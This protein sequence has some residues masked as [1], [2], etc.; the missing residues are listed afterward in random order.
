MISGKENDSREGR[1]EDRPDGSL[2]AD[3]FAA[4]RVSKACDA[5]VRKKRPAVQPLFFGCITT[6]G[7]SISSMLMP[8]CWNVSR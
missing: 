7:M 4:Y 2:G 8:P 3:V 5:M 1:G 6:R